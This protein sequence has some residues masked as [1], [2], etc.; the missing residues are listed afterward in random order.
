V[1]AQKLELLSPAKNKEFGMASICHGAD[2][3]YIGAP[4]FGA[5]SAA[6]NAVSDIEELA[7]FAHLYKAKVYIALN[8]ILFDNELADAEK[9]IDRLWNAGADALIIQDMGL[10]EMDLPPIPLF[11]STQTNNQTLAR[12]QFLE[13]SGFERVILARELGIRQ[14]QEISESTTVSLEA[15]VHGALCACYSG[16]CYFS[17]AIGNRSANRGECGQPCRLPWNLIS[18]AD[19]GVEKNRGAET[20]RVLE[21][22]RHLLSLKDMNRSD[23]LG[24]LAAAGITSF[25]I[26]GRLKDL[27]YVKNITAFYRQKLD[28]LMTTGSVYSPASSGKTTFFFLPDPLKTF[29]RGETDYFLFGRK[30]KIHSFDTPKSLGEKIGRV[31]R[32]DPRYFTLK[33]SHDIQNGDGLCYMDQAGRLQGFQVNSTGQGK[34]YPSGRLNLQKSPLFPGALVYRNHDHLFLKKLGGN[35]SQRRIGLD[36]FFRETAQ[37]F[38]LNGQDEDG[39][40]GE[41]RLDMEK[42][43][44]QNEPAARAALKKQLGKLGA[45]MF[46][47][48]KLTLGSTPCFIPT[49]DLNQLRR[50]L[51]EQMT[52]NRARAYTQAAAIPRPLPSPYPEIQV[53][54]TANVSNEKAIEFYRKRGVTRVDTAFEVSPP[55]PATVVMTLRHCIRQASGACPRETTVL[56]GEWEGPLFI[57]NNK[58]RFQLVFD[59]KR[60]RMKVLTL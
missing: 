1:S 37:G 2:A 54:F 8:T 26:E 34:I 49:R 9:L 3:V 22:D 23:H 28:A 4:R 32:I 48:G 45:S 55:G 40:Q 33:T 39:N 30:G 57:E 46:Y 21:Q 27:A 60:C 16:Q 11:A 56:P 14:I 59:C 12:V 50:T 38:V 47:L 19:Q 36:L 25:K 24:R 53:D 17:A 44:A 6:G 13:A 41:V 42:I 29:N 20:D 35:S 51:L 15:F 52:L 10:L 5:R 18:R 31:D 7:A 43:P 58:G